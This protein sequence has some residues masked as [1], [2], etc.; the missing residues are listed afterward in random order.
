M[1]IITGVFIATA[2]GTIGFC[3]G[4][5]ICGW[6]KQSI[7]VEYN[8]ILKS[9]EDKWMQYIDKIY[10]LHSELMIVL[11][12]GDTSISTITTVATLRTKIM[13]LFDETQMPITAFDPNTK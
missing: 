6:G 9:Q 11:E 2:A 12:R 4:I 8:R 13:N 1:E 7:V 3:F 10:R 5:R